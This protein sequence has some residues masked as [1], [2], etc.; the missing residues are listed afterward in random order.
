MLIIGFGFNDK[1]ITQPFLSAIESNV[2]LKAVVIDPI[3]EN[4]KKTAIQTL[5]SLIKQ[6]DWR[7]ALIADTFQN[8]VS[9]LPDLVAE[10]ETEVHQKRMKAAGGRP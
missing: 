1:H 4:S 9:I 10:S 7:L 2:N 5:A 3:L 6:G 8:V